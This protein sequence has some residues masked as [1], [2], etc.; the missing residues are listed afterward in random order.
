MRH[1]PPKCECD[2]K[3]LSYGKPRP[4]PRWKCQSCGKVFTAAQCNA[5]SILQQSDEPEHKIKTLFDRG[6]DQR[7]AFDPPGANLTGGPPSN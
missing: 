5:L 6:C 7:G 3:L 4:D 2:G 1:R